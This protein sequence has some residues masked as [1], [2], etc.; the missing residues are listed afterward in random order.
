QERDAVRDFGHERAG[1]VVDG[2][3]AYNAADPVDDAAG[4]FVTEITD[5]VTFLHS[6]LDDDL[7]ALLLTPCNVSAC[8]GQAAPYVV[9]DVI[10]VDTI[11]PAGFPNGRTL[12]DQVI[13]I[14]LALILLDLTT[15]S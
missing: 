13:D 3:D 1:C 12:P 9:P 15:D 4:T 11:L 7:T 10:Q 14:T 5:S 2:V 8:V 6:A